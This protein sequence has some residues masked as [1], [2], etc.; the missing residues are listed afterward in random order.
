M[1]EVVQHHRSALE[2]LC[3]NFCVRRLELFGSAATEHFDPETSDLDFLVE[4]QS[5]SSLGP[6]HQ[7]IDFHIALERLFERSIDLVE[8]SAI[9]NPYFRQAIDLGPRE[10]IYAA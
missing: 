1:A 7:Y 5:E 10:L 4:F 8:D 2:Q 3:R 6:F 9:R